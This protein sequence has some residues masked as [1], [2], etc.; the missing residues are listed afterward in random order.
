V[1][2][3]R[4]GARLDY[5][6]ATWPFAKLAVRLDALVLDVALSHYE[7]PRDSIQRLRRYRGL[8]SLGLVIEHTLMDPDVPWLVIFWV[9]DYEAL[10]AALEREGYPD[11]EAMPELK[12]WRD[13]VWHRPR[14]V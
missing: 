6:N 14:P 8:W 11:P 10:R 2:A 7:F 5:F 4:G 1:F 12:W 9:T 13:R 3:Q